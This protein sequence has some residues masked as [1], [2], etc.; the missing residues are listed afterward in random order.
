MRNGRSVLTEWVRRKCYQRS[1]DLNSKA[2]SAAWSQTYVAFQRTLQQSLSLSAG[3]FCWQLI[4]LWFIFPNITTARSQSSPFHMKSLLLIFLFGAPFAW[5]QHADQSDPGPIG[6]AAGFTW[7][8]P[9]LNL[10]IANP[11]GGTIKSWYILAPPRALCTIQVDGTTRFTGRFGNLF[12]SR[13]S[14][15]HTATG[16]DGFTSRYFSV[17]NTALENGYTAGHNA[18][19]DVPFS[20]SVNVSITGDTM[21]STRLPGTPFP[22]MPV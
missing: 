20:D 21:S 1:K 6:T 12:M 11:S 13:A 19:F 2:S 17:T 22:P 5:G 9:T 8:N 15:M 16:N 7:V 14:I 10:K 3:S 4:W 18:Y